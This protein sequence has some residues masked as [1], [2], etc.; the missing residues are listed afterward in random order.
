[1][2]DSLRSI[3]H[4]FPVFLCFLILLSFE[5]MKKQA[6]AGLCQAQVELGLAKMEIFFHMIEN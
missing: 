5:N 3:L 4:M 1:M 6:G 2:P